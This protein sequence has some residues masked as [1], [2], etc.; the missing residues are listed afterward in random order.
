VASFRPFGPSD[1]RAGRRSGVTS[2]SGGA[3]LSGLSGLSAS[4]RGQASVE[5][6]ALL[7]AVVLVA[8]AC[9]QLAVAGHVAW[10]GHAAA[11]AAARASAVGGDP[12]AAALALL[13]GRVRG[14]AVV[15]VARAGSVRVVVPIPF[16][17]GP[18][19][20]GEVEATARF[21]PQT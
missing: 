4:D 19:A 3:G 21:A 7:P 14:D 15:R 17:L 10:S 1:P 5:L 16:V 11:R 13:P 18:G 20:L 2:V 12:R 9:W 8:L 6:V